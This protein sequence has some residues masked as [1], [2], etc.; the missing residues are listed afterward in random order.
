[1]LGSFDATVRIWDCKS[2][3]TKPIQVFEE[4]RDSISSI[5]V[6]EHEIMAGC[7]DGR[8]RT[9]DLRMGMMYV[10]VIAGKHSVST[11]DITLL[12]LSRTMSPTISS[13][14]K[15]LTYRHTPSPA[16]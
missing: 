4:A 7:V 13:K 12:S 5:Y 14:F 15:C 10:D 16:T 1:M 3:S 8:L 11:L 2:Q 6:S 9:Y